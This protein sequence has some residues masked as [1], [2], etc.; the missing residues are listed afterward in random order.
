[1]SRLYLITGFLGSGKST[2]L[3]NFIG[4]FPGKKMQLII[5]EFGR[6]GVDGTLLEELGIGME[7]ITGGSVFCSCRLDQFEE[8]LTTFVE[9]DTDVVLVEASGLSDPTGVRR[10]FADKNRFPNIEYAGAVCLVDAVR[11]PKVYAKSRACLRQVS[12]SD[13]ALINKTDLASKE[14]LEDTRELVRG[15]R[16][17]MPILQTTYGQIDSSLL[18]LLQKQQEAGSGADR[19]MPLIADITTIKMSVR[20]SPQITVYHLRK[21]IEMF[22]ETTFRVKGFVRTDEGMMLVSCTGN[23]VS[24]TP[25]ERPVPA[26][27]EGVLTVLSGAGMPVRKRVREAAA[28]YPDEIGEIT[29]G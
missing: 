7:E 3:K 9:P 2:F 25:W 19:D 16:P 5:N 20:I 18:E 23:V 22:S 11:F 17:D 26:H 1:M 12:A 4:L 6:V 29:L 14:Q 28:W 21:F 27:L 24:V 10:L 15:H 8:A 13:I